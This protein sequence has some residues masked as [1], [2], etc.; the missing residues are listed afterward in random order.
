M[1]SEKQMQAK[2]MSVMSEGKTRPGVVPLKRQKIANRLVI[3]LLAITIVFSGLTIFINLD[4]AI[5]NSILD[6]FASPVIAH[7]ENVLSLF[8]WNTMI[9][10]KTDTMTIRIFWNYALPAGFLFVLFALLILEPFR[11][12]SLGRYVHDK[13]KRPLYKRTG[14]VRNWILWATSLVL[15]SGLLLLHVKS[16]MVMNDDRAQLNI[17]PGFD[18]KA[19][20]ID[21]G[22]YVTAFLVVLGIVL[23]LTAMPSSHNKVVQIDEEGNVYDEQGNPYHS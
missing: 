13:G 7:P 9:F 12:P 10:D 19:T 5:P 16:L 8:T 15:W 23:I 1:V 18:V 6:T 2:K 4:Q 20:E 11:V 3:W 21:M 14:Q 17:K 22:F